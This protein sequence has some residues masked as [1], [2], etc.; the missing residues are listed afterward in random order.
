MD[1]ENRVLCYVYRNPPPGFGKGLKWAAIA[2]RVW[3]TGGRTHPTA[4][5]VR[6]CVLNWRAERRKRGRRKGWKKTTKEEDK[7][8]T[9]CFHKVRLPLGSRVTAREVAT[10]LPKRLR[11][12]ICLRTVRRRLAAKG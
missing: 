8:I 5:G 2:K 9:K 11:G 6:H 7:L 12:K 4:A 3:N 10:E 1:A